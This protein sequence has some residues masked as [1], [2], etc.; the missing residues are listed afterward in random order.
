MNIPSCQ[1]NDA[2]QGVDEPILDYKDGVIAPWAIWELVPSDTVDA[3]GELRAFS[4]VQ[5]SHK[6]DPC[7]VV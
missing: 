5:L 1:S 7:R 4:T 3:R 2:S 6:R